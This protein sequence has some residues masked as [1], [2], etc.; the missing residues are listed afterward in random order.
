MNKKLSVRLYGKEVG[1]L[2]Q[3]ISGKMK[4]TYN[5]DNNIAVSYSLPVSKKYFSDEECRQFFHQ[6]LPNANNIR[7]S[8]CKV[9]GIK[10]N[11]D[12]ALLQAIGRDCAGAISFHDLEEP[13][14]A[15]EYIKLEYTPL[16]DNKLKRYIKEL[17]TRPLFIQAD[18]DV[19]VS[20]AGYQSKSA[21]I[22]INGTVC[23]PKNSAPTT[24]ILKAETKKD[25]GFNTINEYVCMKAAKKLN[26]D[27]CNVE[28]RKIGKMRYLII[29]RYDRKIK[30]NTVKK[31]HQ[32]TFNQALA[33]LYNRYKI[34]C[35]Q[36]ITTKKYIFNLF[37]N[38]LDITAVPDVSRSVF[39]KKII[40]NFIV[41]NNDLHGKQYKGGFHFLDYDYEFL[42]IDAKNFSLVYEGDETIL[43][44]AYDLSCVQVYP[45]KNLTIKNSSIYKKIVT[46]KI[47]ESLCENLKYSYKNFVKE[48][49]YIAQNLHYF[50]EQEKEFF[51]KQEQFFID[52]ILEV[53]DRNSRL[54]DYL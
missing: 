39:M 12:F 6:L 29:E 36:G 17:S 51:N 50:I 24:H 41:G 45:E 7:K 14:K 18:N 43:A 48:F 38:L 46:E 22:F 53:I 33:A 15:E 1:F 3:S 4:F 49:C 27:T 20:L 34:N 25:C 40:F 42:Y 44:P 21:V 8:L 10:S 31:I 54:A 2:E 19:K 5:D 32:E 26:I 13:V 23:L 28:I 52:K 47:F 30:N 9:L 37:N 35:K 16:T 11:D